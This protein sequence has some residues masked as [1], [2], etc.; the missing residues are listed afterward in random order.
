[1]GSENGSH[2][3][4]PR[5]QGVGR[6]PALDAHIQGKLLGSLDH[7]QVHEILCAVVGGRCPAAVTHDNRRHGPL[8]EGVGPVFLGRD[9]SIELLGQGAVGRH[10]QLLALGLTFSEKDLFLLLIN[11]RR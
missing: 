11:E 8:G 1:M 3:L 10:D 4:T 2:S 5:M 7:E 9:P 6:L